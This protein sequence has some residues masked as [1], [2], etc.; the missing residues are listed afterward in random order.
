VVLAADQADV[1]HLAQLAKDK[2]RLKGIKGFYTAAGHELAPGAPLEEGAVILA[3]RGEAFVGKAPPEVEAGAGSLASGEERPLPLPIDSAFARSWVRSDSL[4]SGWRRLRVMS[5]NIL[6]PC[7][8]QGAG[9]ECSV[10]RTSNTGRGARSWGVY[11]TAKKPMHATQPLTHNFS[12]SQAD[13]AWEHRLPRLLH[14]LLL[15]QPDL[16]CLQELDA[17]SWPDIQRALQQRGYCQGISAKAKGGANNFVAMFWKEE[18]LQAVG[19]SEIVYLKAQGTIAAVIQRFRFRCE[20][21][22]FV[23]MTTHLKAGLR[24]KDEQDRSK[25]VDDLLSVLG[26]F[27]KLDD[28]V[29][30]TGDFNAHLEDLHF[31]GDYGAD[32]ASK[33]PGLAL[34][35]LL[36][37]GFRCAVQEATGG[38][39]LAFSQWCWRSDVEIRS[40][41]DHV[42]LRGPSLA[43]QA[44]LAAPSEAEVIEAGGLPNARHPSDH[45]PVVVDIGF[46]VEPAHAVAQGAALLASP[47]V[48]ASLSEKYLLR[49]GQDLPQSGRVALT[50]DGFKY[51][52]LPKEWQAA[53]QQFVDAAAA[54]HAASMKDVLEADRAALQRN[55]IKQHGFSQGQ[56]AWGFWSPP[57]TVGIHISLGKHADSLGVG[58]RVRFQ[59]RRLLDFQKRILGA[60][61]SSVGMFCARWFTYEVALVDEARC[62]GEEPHISF[63]IFGAR[64]V[65]VCEAG[66]Y[67][68]DAVE[69]PPVDGHSTRNSQ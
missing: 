66:G 53:R 65:G 55:L 38:R 25:L 22:E 9:L 30:F 67:T 56:L 49:L 35:R 58:R 47:A 7:L 26:N 3:H 54:L 36:K 40:V 32:G 52:S 39:P 31:F 41:I 61:S 37:A 12:C 34:P 2:L 33:L 46:E 8:A 21:P 28:I 24:L 19:E 4:V 68:G 1:K 63:A 44:S 43:S 11:P 13:L 15:P 51:V 17:I 5:F 20:G 27:T 42:L 14:E 57:S 23:A 48:Q 59:V 50:E 10:G 18:V 16:I 45:I 64:F 60:P 29:F 6:A 69:P 62:E